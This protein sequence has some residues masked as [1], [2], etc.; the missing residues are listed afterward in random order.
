[1][2]FAVLNYFDKCR[3][4]R[5]NVFQATVAAP[6]ALS[7]EVDDKLRVRQRMGLEHEHLSRLYFIAPAGYF[8]SL[9]VLGEAVLELKRDA[10][11]HYAD[12]VDRVD[13]CLHIRAQ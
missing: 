3:Q 5:V 6:V 1:M 9:E 11:A 12:T 10:T 8:I 2:D 7:W 13:K 4:P